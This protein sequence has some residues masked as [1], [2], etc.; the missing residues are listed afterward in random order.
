MTYDINNFT[1]DFQEFRPHLKSFI[2][3][4]TASVGKSP[5]NSFIRL[6]KIKREVSKNKYL[7][8]II[9]CFNIV[10]KI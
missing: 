3:R 10:F 5:I 9:K 7:T 2:L 8:N 6:R 1:Y 4:M